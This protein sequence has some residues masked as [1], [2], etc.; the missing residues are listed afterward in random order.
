[1]FRITLVYQDDSS[2][3]PESAQ[4]PGNK[5]DASAEDIVEAVTKPLKASSKGKTEPGSSKTTTSNK[6]VKFKIKA[7]PKVK[8][9]P[10]IKEEPTRKQNTGTSSH[11]RKPSRDLH[12]EGVA[13]RSLNRG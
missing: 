12:R 6:E 13:T 4:K 5:F 7:E 8:Q 9:E 3:P 2:P 1:M 10:Y 11:K